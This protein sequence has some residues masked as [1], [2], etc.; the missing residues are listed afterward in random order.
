MVCDVG[1]RSQERLEL[2]DVGDVAPSSTLCSGQPGVA[3]ACSSMRRRHPL[4]GCT[5]TEGL[6]GPLRLALVGHSCLR[7][8]SG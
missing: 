6:A 4:A 2:L 1:K 7:L 3:L 8:G 5:S